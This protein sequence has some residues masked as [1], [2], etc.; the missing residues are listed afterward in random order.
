MTQDEL[1]ES[2]RAALG[3]PEYGEGQ[4]APEIAAILGVHAAKARIAIRKML[5]DGSMETV[6]LRRT[7][8]NGLPT[9]IIGYRLRG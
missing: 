4:T 9:T 1:L 7:K 3:T 6:R 2:L 5:T 8:M